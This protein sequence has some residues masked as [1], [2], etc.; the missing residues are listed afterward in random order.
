MKRAYQKPKSVVVNVHLRNHLMD[1]SD[2]QN[3]EYVG[4][5]EAGGFDTKGFTWG[6]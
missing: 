6:W 4:T 3:V 1:G 5:G 2:P